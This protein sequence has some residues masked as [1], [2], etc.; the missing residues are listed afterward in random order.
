MTDVKR[1]EHVCRIAV[2]LACLTG[3]GQ[4]QAAE[5]MAEW[6]FED[7]QGSVA[8]DGSSHRNDGSLRNGSARVEEGI[9][10][11]LELDGVDDYVDCGSADRL[12]ITKQ[13]TLEA[14]VFP[15]DP[16]SGVGEPLLLG[17]GIESYGLVYNPGQAWFYI[18]NGAWH[19]KAEIPTKKWTHVVG[20]YDGT[21][22]KLYING[23]FHAGYVM[24][25]ANTRIK[26]PSEHWN[27]GGK[28]LIGKRGDAYF[29]GLIDNARIYNGPL[30]AQEVRAQYLA[31]EKLVKRPPPVPRENLTGLALKV[32]DAGRDQV[33]LP[34]ESRETLESDLSIPP[35]VV[36]KFVGNGF[37][38][39]GK[40]ATLTIAGPVE[41]HAMRIFGGSGKVVFTGGLVERSYPQWWGAVADDAGDDTAA[42]QAAIDSRPVSGVVFFPSGRYRISSRLK[43]RSGIVLAGALAKS[44]IHASKALPAM[45]QRPDLTPPPDGIHYNETT[46]INNVRI[47]DL[48]FNG[49]GSTIGLDLTNINYVW[50]QNVSVSN[51]KTGI[52]LAELG[53]YDVF[54]NLAI[55]RCD[56]GI[57]FNVGSMNNNIFGGIISVCKTGIL[58]NTTGQLNIYGIAFDLFTETGL[59]FRNG[60]HVNLHYPWFDSVE[61][62]IPVKIGPRVTGCTVVNPRFSGPTPKVIEDGTDGKGAVIINTNEAVKS[63]LS[64]ELLEARGLFTA[65]L[66]ATD[67][68]ARNLRGSVSIAGGSK[69]VEVIFATPEPDANYFVTATAVSAEGNPSAAA[70]NVHIAE[71]SPE[72]F[73]IGA[74]EPPGEGGSVK[75]DWILVR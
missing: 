28:V 17:T 58:I 18:S 8:K 59:D 65:G 19:C 30:S 5:L 50:M 13:V 2:V 64:A 56:T 22:M 3:A 15:T 27:S 29:R 34:I 25:A 55:A 26:G 69:M 54:I 48:D 16:T 35:N 67:T 7:D 10:Q 23:E 36:L 41:A 70:R 21:K 47:T 44:K 31:E 39:I 45:L 60:N 46:R 32:H 12:D 40:G 71:K 72:G 68:I 63:T 75:I 43:V 14:W 53:M 61:P 9:G 62:A 33:T 1:S 51:C 57:E 11:A 42:I 20:T 52:M 74:Q 6:K 66:S 24:S 37:C 38:E 73:T 4:V 49:E